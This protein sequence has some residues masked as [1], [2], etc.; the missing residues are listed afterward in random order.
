SAFSSPIE[1][2]NFIGFAQKE[3]NKNGG[4]YPFRKTEKPP[5]ALGILCLIPLIGAFAGLVFI[6]LGMA[7]YKDKWF[8]L[9]GVAGILITVI[10]YSSLIY[11]SK[12]SQVARQG[13][14]KHS[15]TH[16]NSLVSTVEFY[17]TENGQYPDSLQQ[18][19]RGN[20]MVWIRDLLQ[21]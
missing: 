10:V 6:F 2:I 8:T 3:I 15:Q 16:L 21:R 14:E 12:N 19:K 1:R 20:E 4:R 11:F 17:K 5:Y 18:L 7:K 9:M 13:F